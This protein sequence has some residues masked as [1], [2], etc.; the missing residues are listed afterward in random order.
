MT[1]L[2]NTQISANNNPIGAKKLK[3][4]QNSSGYI[5]AP[6]TMYRYSINQELKEKDE[7]RKQIVQ[8]NY[9]SY[10]KKDNTMAKMT[11]ILAAIAG[12]FALTTKK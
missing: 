7:F 1:N 10:H 4:A 11:F 5:E 8:Q 3:N 9:K 12:F 6:Q 2:L